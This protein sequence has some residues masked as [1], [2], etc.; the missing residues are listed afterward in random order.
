MKKVL[1]Y[2]FIDTSVFQ[3]ERFFKESGRISK[4]LKLSEDGYIRILLPIITEKEWLKHIKEKTVFTLQSSDV[5]KKLALLGQNKTVSD[6]LNQYKS[7]LDNNESLIESA[8]QKKISHKGVIRI[9][10]PFFEDA[11]AEVFNKYFKQE[12]PFGHG[13]KAKEFP[14]AF[15]LASL[16]KYAKE[17]K[18]DR[19][20]IFSSDKDITE[21]DCKLFV[22]KKI[23]E[24]LNDLLKDRIPAEKKEKQ[25]KDLDFLNNYIHEF[26]PEFESALRERVEQYLLD[27]DCYMHRFCYTDVDDIFGL[28]FSLDMPMKDIDMLSVSDE[29]IEAVCFPEIKGKVQ[30]SYFD[31]EDSVWDSEDKT[32]IF[33]SYKTTEVEISSYFS[34]T[35]RM[36][37]NVLGMGQD[38]YV[39]I[40]DV[41]FSSLQSSIDDENY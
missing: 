19:V 24:Y 27:T 38:P 20:V 37:R 17:N 12:K 21:Y 26:R 22:N 25:R 3:Q 32:W 15:A 13:R 36:E 10:Y 39:E 29:T 35:V 7:L 1:D 28:T 4:L 40:V 9:D 2:I 18:L 23:D 30:V 41:D 33:E 11:T 31:E 5:E 6:F 14:D 8:F 16:E 34:V